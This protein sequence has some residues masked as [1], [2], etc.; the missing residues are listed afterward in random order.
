MARVRAQGEKVESPEALEGSR[1]AG[2]VVRCSEGTL[3]LLKATS[4]SHTALQ[5]KRMCVCG[6][7]EA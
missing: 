5:H 2:E 3:T 7:V 4:K 6:T 1:M